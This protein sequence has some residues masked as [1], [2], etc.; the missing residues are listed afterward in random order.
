MNS[1]LQTLFM[2]P[3]FRSALYGWRYRPETD[4][5]ER[6]C[7]PLQLQRLFARLCL[8]ECA[9]IETKNVTDS[10]GWSDNQVFQQQDVQELIRVLLDAIDKTF[11]ANGIE[12]PITYETLHTRMH[13][14]FSTG[15]KRYE[16]T[17]CSGSGSQAPLSRSASRLSQVHGMQFFTH[18]IGRIHGHSFGHPWRHITR[19]SS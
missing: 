13:S 16:L 17:D 1:L 8:S 7:I 18:Q 10:F 5:E 11:H 15:N 3:E 19:R 12:N 4:G 6:L 9:H 14:L 2:T